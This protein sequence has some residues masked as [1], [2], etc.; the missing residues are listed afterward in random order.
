MARA[1]TFWP[2]GLGWNEAF[3]NPLRV[4]NPNTQAEDPA[5]T[6]CPSGLVPELDHVPRTGAQP[7]SRDVAAI[8]WFSEPAPIARST[9]RPC[10]VV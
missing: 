6:P 5:Q 9:V 2:V 4:V 3:E 7:G 1:I 8:C 10:V